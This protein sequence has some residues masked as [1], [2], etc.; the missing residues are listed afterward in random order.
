MSA[1]K[2]DKGEGS[3]EKCIDVSKEAKSCIEKLLGDV[4]KSSATKQMIIGG[5][6]G[7]YYIFYVIIFVCII[8]AS[9]FSC[10]LSVVYFI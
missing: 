9:K 3:E 2:K 1:P 6:T 10:H 8:Q 4:S 5:T 7:W